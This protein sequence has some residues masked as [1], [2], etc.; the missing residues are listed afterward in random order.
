MS[1]ITLI[2]GANQGIGLATATKLAADHGHHVIVG[3]RSAEAGAKVAAS[4]QSEG[5]SASSVQLD[6]GSD[7]SIVAAA[8]T[9]KQQF[10][11][12]DVLINNAGILIDG[13]TP[14]QPI[15]DLFTQTFATNVIGTACLTEA[16]L[17]L[18][19]KSALPRVVFVSSRM[20]SLEQATNHDTPF[21]ASDYKAYDASK[22]AVNMV[23]LNYARILEDV[24]GRVNVA[25]PGLVATGLTGYV[26]YGA[27]PQ[28]GAQR[29]VELATVGKDGP[30]MTF[31]DRDG[32]VA[33]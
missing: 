21:F 14:D 33:W 13:K 8:E 17:P 7:A 29:I 3:A 24:G 32:E 27:T 18:L 15:R 31:S 23:A 26:S 10:G 6:L 19:R 2:S 1:T 30:T 22:A 9:I 25:C 28:L 5:H 11:R 4:L 20:G 16:M 12:L